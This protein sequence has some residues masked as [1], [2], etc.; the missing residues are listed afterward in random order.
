VPT[1]AHLHVGIPINSPADLVRAAQRF[2]VTPPANQRD[3]DDWEAAFSSVA[4]TIEGQPVGLDIRWDD[5]VGPWQQPYQNTVT[6]KPGDSYT[7]I[8]AQLTSRYSPAIVDEG[9]TRGGRSEP[10]V[11]DLIRLAKILAAVRKVWPEA[12]ILMMDQ[13]H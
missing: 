3:L 10:F 5:D 2:G 13:M 7:M 6:G 11:L 12:E 8:G 9:W 4:L 1:Q